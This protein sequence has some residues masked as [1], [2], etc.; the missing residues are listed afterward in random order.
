MR[1]RHFRHA[2]IGPEL[3]PF[4]DK[5]P[6][7]IDQSDQNLYPPHATPS[8]GLTGNNGKEFFRCRAGLF[9]TEQYSEIFR[10]LPSTMTARPKSS[11]RTTANIVCLYSTP[12]A[13]TNVYRDSVM[14]SY[15][16]PHYLTKKW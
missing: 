7:R 2:N 8:P 13:S 1:C 12:A 5:F 3:M 6:G 9:Q 10:P 4:R 15:S 11:S 16:N 14:T